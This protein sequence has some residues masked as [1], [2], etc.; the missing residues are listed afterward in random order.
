[1][2]KWSASHKPVLLPYPCSMGGHLLI[3]CLSDPW[4]LVWLGWCAGCGDRWSCWCC[5]WG[6]GCC[7]LL[8]KGL[9][10]EWQHAA[11]APVVNDDRN[12]HNGSFFM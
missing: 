7:A 11:D 5:S 9:L 6:A 4:E 1:M 8:D 12:M 3:C 10:L 2:A